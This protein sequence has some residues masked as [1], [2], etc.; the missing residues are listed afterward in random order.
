ML[1]EGIDHFICM[2][3]TI[4]Q[5]IAKKEAKRLVV[6]KRS[7]SAGLLYE[8]LRAYIWKKWV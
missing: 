4:S 1:P 3:V 6:R 7:F 2:K 8:R 5:Q